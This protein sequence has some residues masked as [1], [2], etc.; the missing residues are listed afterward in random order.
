MDNGYGTATAQRTGS[1]IRNKVYRLNPNYDSFVQILVKDPQGRIVGHLADGLVH[2]LDFT[3]Q[4]P[5]AA[6]A[7]GDIR[8]LRDLE[9]AIAGAREA[10]ASSTG[11]PL[12]SASNK[13]IVF[14]ASYARSVREAVHSQAHQI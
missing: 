10:A 3:E 2:A 7:K 1:D 8:V 11:T 6:I 5:I 13:A 9:T 4:H 14:L 12:E